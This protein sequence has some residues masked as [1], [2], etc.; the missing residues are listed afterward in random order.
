MTLWSYLCCFCFST[1]RFLNSTGHDPIKI[2]LGC[3]Y[4]VYLG[5][6]LCASLPGQWEMC[7]AASLSA[8][9]VGP[10]GSV[11]KEEAGVLVRPSIRE[12]QDC[13]SL[14]GGHSY[15][16]RIYGCGPGQDNLLNSKL[17]VRMGKK[18]DLSNFE[19][20]T[21]VGISQPAHL[22]GLSVSL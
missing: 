3:V 16:E 1:S 19:R 12:H 4:R 20:G 15:T 10:C 7:P 11:S 9:S 5:V 2:M 18:G 17:N 22:L 6:H 8:G 21:F 14:S 13:H